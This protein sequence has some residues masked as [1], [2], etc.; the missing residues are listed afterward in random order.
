MLRSMLPFRLYRRRHAT[1][2]CETRHG[3]AGSSALLR[4]LVVS[5]SFVALHRMVRAALIAKR[6]NS[7]ARRQGSTAATK[8]STGRGLPGGTL[9]VCILAGGLSSRMGR[10][11]S[12]LRLRGLTLLGHGRRLAR[13]LRVPVRT[14]RKDLVPR[15]GPLGGVYTAL[16]TTL[17]ASILFLSCD[18]PFVSI[19]LLTR[20]IV[21]HQRR[22]KPVFVAED[23]VAG[24]PFLLPRASLV[25]VES[26][27][28]TNRFSLQELAAVLQ[29]R[30]I[31]PQGR[32]RRQLLNINTPEELGIARRYRARAGNVG[33]SLSGAPRACKVRTC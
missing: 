11:K 14:I 19:G 25:R 5:C 10:D 3:G 18:M 22:K 8:R 24:F 12:R 29:A 6:S 31:C 17:A 20:L 4:C 2:N 26:Q 27:L 7:K 33:T 13:G 9:E 30:T 23:G 28:A 16:L 21:R 32:S 15:C 1:R